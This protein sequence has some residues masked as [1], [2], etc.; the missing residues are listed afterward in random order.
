MSETKEVKQE[1]EFKLKKKTPKMKGQGNIVPEVTKIDLSK[2]T[3]EDAIKVGETENV[4][5]DKQ[6]TN[7]PEVE[8]EVR[9]DSS[10]ITKVDLKE[11]VESPLELVEDESSNP[12]EITMVEIGRAHV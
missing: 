10:E 11:K 9:G 2:K 1:G 8:K 6:T 3:E 4:V 7:L 12:E 5:D